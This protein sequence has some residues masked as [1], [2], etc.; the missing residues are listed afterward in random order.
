MLYAAKETKIQLDVVYIPHLSKDKAMYRE[1][2][3]GTDI[4]IRCEIQRTEKLEMEPIY[5]KRTIM[6]RKGGKRVAIPRT[7]VCAEQGPFP[8]STEEESRQIAGS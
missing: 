2:I 6:E 4:D 1:T 7:Q 5:I 8:I 3:K